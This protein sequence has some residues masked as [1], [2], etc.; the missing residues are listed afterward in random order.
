[1]YRALSESEIKDV[2]QAQAVGHLGCYAD[3]RMYV[4]PTA[5]YYEDYNV[6]AFA[7]EGQKIAMMRN[8]P[9]VCIQ[10]ENV[11]ETGTWQSVIVWGTFHEVSD[12]DRP[13]VIAK[14]S[15]HLYGQHLEG[16]LVYAPFRSKETMLDACMKEKDMIVYRIEM[17]DWTGRREEVR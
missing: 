14:L 6:Y 8:N 16:K 10:V 15:A 1:M 11:E 4:V 3:N 17:H 9:E 12:D 5:Y 13:D 7:V 2:L